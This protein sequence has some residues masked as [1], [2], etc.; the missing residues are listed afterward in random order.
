MPTEFE[1]NRTKTEGGVGFF[2]ENRKNRD[3][4]RVS[5]CS[6]FLYAI[7]MKGH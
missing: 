5:R 2:S 1:R 3:K 7:P 6:S 4:N